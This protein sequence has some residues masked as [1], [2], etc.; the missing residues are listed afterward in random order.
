M[1]EYKPASKIK[2]QAEKINLNYLK[3][4]HVIHG[5]GKPYGVIKNY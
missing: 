5:K 1:Q 4:R 3:E 2:S